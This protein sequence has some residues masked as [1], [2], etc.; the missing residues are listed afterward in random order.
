MNK[1]TQLQAAISRTEKALSWVEKEILFHAPNM[2][3][4]YPYPHSKDM[5]NLLLRM[6]DKYNTISIRLWNILV[7]KLLGD[8][9]LKWN[10][11][12]DKRYSNYSV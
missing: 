8:G 4:K 5:L 2:F 11:N 6:Q 9:P 12:L 10:P 7:P 1:Q 3:G